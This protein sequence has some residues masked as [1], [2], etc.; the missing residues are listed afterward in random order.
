V[1]WDDETASK[2]KAE[3]DVSA[4]AVAVA[5]EAVAAAVLVAG[6]GVAHGIAPNTTT[7]TSLITTISP[8][9]REKRGSFGF[10]KRTQSLL[11]RLGSG[12]PTIG[13]T[14]HGASSRVAVDLLNYAGSDDDERGGEGGSGNSNG[15]GKKYS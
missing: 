11:Q 7:A 10:E 15:G 8:D 1:D 5:G 6:G 12:S 4:D 2:V 14:R 13:S 9:D 3:E